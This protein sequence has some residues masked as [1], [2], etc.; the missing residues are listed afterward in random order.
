MRPA[1]PVA[2]A[3]VF[4]LLLAACASGTA[5]DTAD[6]PT[7]AATEPDIDP[8]G[9]DSEALD[10]VAEAAANTADQG[11]TRFEITLQSAGTQGADGTQPVTVEGEEDF[12]A[13]QRR[14]TFQAPNG[15][16]EMIIDGTDVYIQLPATEDEQWARVEL[17]DLIG[18]GVGFGGPGGL[19][20][21]SPQENLAVLS[22][23]ATG[24]EEG[25]TED[26]RGESTTRYDLTVDLER[27]ADDLEDGNE[28][29]Q[30]LAQQS[31]V[32]ELGMQVW[33]DDADLIRRIAYTLDLS[34]AEVDADEVEGAEVEAEP[35]GSVTITI[36][37]F[38][39][40]A[41]LDITLPDDDA[42]VDIDEDAIRG[43]MPSDGSVGGTT[44]D[45]TGN[46]GDDD[47]STPTPEASPSP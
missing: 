31:G 39:F 28:T 23:A 10:R 12:A 36:E 9:M 30:Q 24:A 46:T 40:G 20:F 15:E 13:E 35:E 14:M 5:T 27:A 1:L 17:D 42:I 4:A 33:I 32:T 44:D 37:Y 45:D 38:D 8:A 26:V 34:Q 3:A 29:A 25:D 6:S 11:T 19:P 21:Q 22:N 18:D 47:T 43:S 2:L 41:T 16:L 7:A